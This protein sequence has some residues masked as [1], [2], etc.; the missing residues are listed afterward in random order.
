MEDFRIRR[1]HKKRTRKPEG[2]RAEPVYMDRIM[3]TTRHG[4]VIREM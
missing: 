2:I 1:L 3:D 4:L